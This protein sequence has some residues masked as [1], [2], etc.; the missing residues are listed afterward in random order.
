MTVPADMQEPFV[1]SS[2]DRSSVHIDIQTAQRV[3][4][5]TPG[6]ESFRTNSGLSSPFP[7]T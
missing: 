1:M 2:S 6:L 5:R 3:E 7:D 4:Q